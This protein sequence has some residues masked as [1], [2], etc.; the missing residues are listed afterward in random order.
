MAV[1]FAVETVTADVDMAMSQL[2]E[3]LEQMTFA[4][5]RFSGQHK[6]VTKAMAALLVAMEDVKPYLDD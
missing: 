3:A 5:H 2:R 1:R 6:K 4:R